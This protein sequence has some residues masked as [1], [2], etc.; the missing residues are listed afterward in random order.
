MELM[1]ELYADMPRQG[2]GSNGSTEKAY[3]LLQPVIDKPRILDMGC[4]SGI[5][6]VELARLSKGFVLGLDNHQPF[7]E[8]LK[9]RV[10]EAGLS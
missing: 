6:T 5:Q 9:N 8:K 10:G 4:G 1:Y 7:L 3:L 2:P